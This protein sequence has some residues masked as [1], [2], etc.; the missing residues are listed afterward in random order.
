[1]TS[2]APETEDSPARDGEPLPMGL[3]E[4]SET[5]VSLACEMTPQS[6]AELAQTWNL[7]DLHRGMEAREIPRPRVIKVL[8]G[9]YL[10]EN[11]TISLPQF[12]N[13]LTSAEMEDVVRNKITDTFENNFSELRN[14]VLANSLTDKETITLAGKITFYWNN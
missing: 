13:S 7:Q 6:V 11:K 14:I 2:S 3:N 4:A 8:C 10:K 5:L 12:L 9:K 1:M